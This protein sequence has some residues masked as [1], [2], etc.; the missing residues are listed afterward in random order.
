MRQTPD[1]I[2]RTY[3]IIEETANSDAVI[4]A[5]SGFLGFPFTLIA[6]GTTVLTNYVPMLNK[7]RAL[8]DKEPWTLSSFGPVFKALSNELL[9][10]VLFDKVLGNVPLVGIYFNYICAKSLTWRL[11][12]LCAMCSCLDADINDIEILKK[13]VIL[14]REVFPQKS[15]FS[16]SAPDYGTFKKLMTSL[17]NNSEDVFR[18]KIAQA[19]T[20][21]E[22]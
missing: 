13:T 8:Y 2:L 20:A 9:F 15:V 16:F 19:L 14:I 3:Q 17:V 5:I 4:E 6:D 12:M 7:I 18:N 10:D 1:E 21:F 22:L 11:G